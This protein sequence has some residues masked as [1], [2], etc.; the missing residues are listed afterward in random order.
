MR[1]EV[2]GDATSGDNGAFLTLIRSVTAFWSPLPPLSAVLVR[3][4]MYA[5]VADVSH[6]ALRLF[7][8]SIL[9]AWVVLAPVRMRRMVQACR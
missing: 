8:A 3:V 5:P 6:A 7:Q 9:G 4:C 1:D 2:K